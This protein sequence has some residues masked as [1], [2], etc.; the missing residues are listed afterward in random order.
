MPTGVTVADGLKSW[1]QAAVSVRLLPPRAKG[2]TFTVA[3]ASMEMRKVSGA[4]SA[5]A[6]IS[7]TCSKIAS[8]SGIFFWVHSWRPF[9]AGLAIPAEFAFGAALPT[10]S[11]LFDGAGYEEPA[12]TALQ[13]LG[14]FDE[15]RFE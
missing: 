2:P 10:R 9:A 5:A 14:S 8:G 4:A 3:L 15:Q 11:Q 1:S 6:F 7:L 13:R 12:G